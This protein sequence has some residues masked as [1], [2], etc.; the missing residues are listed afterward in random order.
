M[1]VGA[2]SPPHVPGACAHGE[3]V[4]QVAVCPAVKG[5]LQEGVYLLLDLCLEPDVRFLRASLPPG[6][7]DA[8]TQLHGDYVKCH[9]AARG[10]EGRYGA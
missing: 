3:R 4:L 5:H 8:F 6:A 7:R 10:S 9:Q 1:G 2:G